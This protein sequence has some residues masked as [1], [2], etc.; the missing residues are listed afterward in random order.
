MAK[1]K[2]KLTLSGP[3]LLVLA[4]LLATLPGWGAAPAAQRTRLILSIMV[5]GLRSDYLEMLEEKFGPDGFK[6]LMHNGV[7]IDEVEFGPNMDAAGAIAMLYTGASPSVSGISSATV[8]SPELRMEQSALL[9]PSKIGNYTDETLS[10]S[11][12]RVSTLSDEL[13]IDGGGASF[14]H[15]LAPNPSE[16]ILMGGH[17]G[18]SA[19]WLNNANGQWATTTHYVEVP[20]AVG[21]ANFTHPLAARLDTMLWA[22]SISLKEYPGLPEHK[23]HYGFRHTFSSADPN[24]YRRFKT[25]PLVNRELTDLALSYLRTLNLGKREATDMLSIAYT[26]EPYAEG[27]DVGGRVEQMDAYLRLDRDLARLF[28]AAGDASGLVVLLA[29]TPAAPSQEQ[30]D[31]KWLLPSSEFSARKAVSLLNM[32]LIAQHGNG[33][34]VTAYNRGAFYLNRKLID[35]KALN[36]ESLR[37]DAAKFLTRMTGVGNAYTIDDIQE[38]RAGEPLR[39]NTAVATAPDIFI[40]VLPGRVLIDDTKT[41]ATTQT[42]RLAPA[43]AP[44]YI[45]APERIEVDRIS[46]PVDARRIAPTMARLLRIR[47]PNAASL[48]PIPLHSKSNY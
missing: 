35:E 10:P 43:A 33:E 26:L 17:S 46:T 48:P 27:T 12:L 7:T 29:G 22:P 28:K 19:F 31:P 13:R 30:D 15:A 3:G 41:P 38:G 20:Q 11:A 6:R 45:Y 34:W 24:R 44:A 9:D 14:S 47:S 2:K 23:R 16:A 42:V 8:Y 5:E 36:P 32:Y 25:T 39:R 21:A 40:E 18:N 1:K 37:D 4:T